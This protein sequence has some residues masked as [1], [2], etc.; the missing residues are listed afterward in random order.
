M[1]KVLLVVFL[2]IL[3]VAVP[4]F[5][6]AKVF[7]VGQSINPNSAEHL[8]ALIA[9]TVFAGGIGLLASWLMVRENLTSV[10]VIEVLVAEGRRPSRS[11][12]L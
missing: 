4:A 2:N 5:G 10:D 12:A 8:L 9:V 6:L 11:Q 1:R 3:A 7:G